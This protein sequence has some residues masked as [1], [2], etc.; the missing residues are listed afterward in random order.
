MNIRINKWSSKSKLNPWC[1][2]R[3]LI[4]ANGWTKNLLTTMIRAQS[5]R[6]KSIYKIKWWR[7]KDMQ[8]S[9]I[10]GFRWVS[11]LNLM[12]ARCRRYPHRELEKTVFICQIDRLPPSLSQFANLNNT[13][14]KKWIKICKIY[15]KLNHPEND[16]K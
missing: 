10:Q 8:M 1:L 3:S 7:L 11:N 5:H 12:Q 6:K 16:K 2:F 9:Q 13:R 15:K 4:Q 14:R